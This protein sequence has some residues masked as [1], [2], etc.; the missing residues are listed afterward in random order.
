MHCCSGEIVFVEDASYGPKTRPDGSS[1]EGR[2]QVR[3]LLAP[4]FGSPIKVNVADSVLIA[5][6]LDRSTVVKG[7]HV[8]CGLTSRVKKGQEGTEFEASDIVKGTLT[9]V[10]GK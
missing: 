1:Y 2:A 7:M 9:V 4:D 10:P 5:G 8:V 3:L 6:G